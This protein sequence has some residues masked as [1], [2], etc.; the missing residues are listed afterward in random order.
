MHSISEW[1]M[2]L[3]FFVFILIMLS[4]DIF[5]LG[6]KKAHRVSIKEALG[7]VIVWVALA[8]MFNLL[9]WAY[10]T[11][12]SDSAIASQKSMEFFTGYLIEE[13]LS[14]DN[15]FIFIMLFGYFAVPAKYQ[16]R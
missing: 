13:S 9:L 16:R 7:W 10:L 3:S 15:M 14:V 12:T 6:G 1:W 2:W 11:H 8:L 5:L 4:V